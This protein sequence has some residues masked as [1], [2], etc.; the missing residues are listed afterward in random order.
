MKKQVLLL[1]ALFAVI[2]ASALAQVPTT[3]NLQG[4]LTGP[5]DEPFNGTVTMEFQM[6][7]DPDNLGSVVHTESLG[8]VTVTDGYYNLRI[9]VAPN[10]IGNVVNLAK[11]PL[12][13]QLVV[14]GTPQ[15]AKPIPFD[16]TP[17]SFGSKF[18]EV[19][20]N[21]DSA[22]Y[23]KVAGE[24]R[25]IG[26][27][28]G[29]L[30]GEYPDKLELD[31][32]ALKGQLDIMLE[33]ISA[34]PKGPADGD[35]TGTYPDKLRIKERHVTGVQL[36]Y[37]TITA[38]N[39]RNGSVTLDKVATPSNQNTN[40]FLWWNKATGRYEQ[41]TLNK[42]IADG[43]MT[44]GYIPTW[45]ED[46]DY[47]VPS[48]IWINPSNTLVKL[49]D[50]TNFDVTGLTTLNDLTVTGSTNIDGSL[51]VASKAILNGGATIFGIPT[52]GT[53]VVNRNY[54]DAQ[55]GPINTELARIDAQVIANTAAIATKASIAD[56]NN[57]S[58]TVSNLANTVNQKADKTELNA[59]AAIVDTKASQTDLTA[60]T[61]VVATKASQADLL[62][63]DSDLDALTAVVDT[64]A[65]QTALDALTAVVATKAAQTDLD[66]LT[67]VVDGKATQVALIDTAAALR[68]YID[69]K[70]SINVPN[71]TI[72]K[73]DASGNL[74]ASNITDDDYVVTI[75][76]GL[77]VDNIA[78]P[79]N[80]GQTQ[81]TG[82]VY[83][84]GSSNA[85]STNTFTTSIATIGNGTLNLGRYS[86]SQGN[87]TGTATKING[88]NVD[89][90]AASYGLLQGTTGTAVNVAGLNVDI[91]GAT[92]NLNTGQLPAGN[93][94]QRSTNIGND[95]SPAVTINSQAINIG[96]GSGVIIPPPPPNTNAINIGSDNSVTNINGTVSFAKSFLVPTPTLDTTS[97]NL[98]VVN[99]QYVADRIL[100][101]T[102]G[103]TNPDVIWDIETSTGYI[104]LATGRPSPTEPRRFQNSPLLVTTIDD[105]G[106][107][108]SKI[109][110]DGLIYAL[111][112]VANRN[113]EVVN[114]NITVGT[115]NNQIAIGNNTINLATDLIISKSVVGAGLTSI[116]LGNDILNDVDALDNFSVN[117][118]GNLV[119]RGT[120]QL[121]GTTTLRG[122]LNVIGTATADFNNAVTFWG[123][124]TAQ[125]P[126]VASHV[127][128]KGYVDDAISAA[129]S[130]LGG[131]AGLDEVDDNYIP[132]VEGG[133]L[134][135][136]PIYRN[137]FGSLFTSDIMAI[138]TS[139]VI[140]NN[141]WIHGN[142]IICDPDIWYGSTDP[143]TKSLFIGGT[144]LDI[145]GNCYNADGS[146]NDDV[147]ADEYKWWYTGA[148]N[149]IIHK[150]QPAGL[151]IFADDFFD[152]NI[153]YD[154]TGG[155]AELFGVYVDLSNEYGT[156]VAYPRAYAGKFL[157]NSAGTYATVFIKNL[158]SPAYSSAPRD[159]AALFVNGGINL[160]G[161]ISSFVEEHKTS[162]PINPSQSSSWRVSTDVTTIPAGT[163]GQI[164][165]IINTSASQV[166]VNGT[167]IAGKKAQ[168][169]ICYAGEW[170]PFQ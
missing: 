89:I 30:S 32:N 1:I 161:P 11:N 24:A 72:P 91:E 149:A 51:N 95:L 129:V 3:L 165:Y 158:A 98:T 88:L 117:S 9:G 115:G 38:E 47:F 100:E 84:N 35:I 15:F 166:T 151:A 22:E 122:N 7:T 155:P 40:S 65:N 133:V 159:N 56:L 63:L 62:A 10:T 154:Q 94:Y 121:Y 111:D 152:A 61:A 170:Y 137:V 164:M 28:G 31:P 46:A 14:N 57:L 148:I 16:A 90:G 48:P 5:N 76:K 37:N 118:N 126:T 54:V 109:T 146:W 34:T 85:G 103:L 107:D 52:S 4:F 83:I 71:N 139:L 93:S 2:T 101:A 81:I 74:V 160:D 73:A 128:T 36:D 26:P 162:R 19:S 134:V 136:S 92:L 75:T 25:P 39:I 123:T 70:A 138:D 153:Y 49:G 20:A 79:A 80:S 127:A 110:S 163:N 23:A 157:S 13:Y 140:D 77:V 53:D 67:L 29:I 150:D 119:A 168:M 106:T 60:L 124:A 43:W 12:Y 8:S 116:R 17:F 112:F 120:T 78:G 132:I 96:V 156:Q 68:A 143:V 108:R 27:A 99:K 87:N 102:M 113:V 45:N 18:A 59:L 130:G 145:I 142:T 82:P 33:N 144:P 97:S 147:E 21:A 105:N 50:G 6:F 114:G 64:K 66:A 42:V 44:D 69:A 135:N 169:F 167:D 104:P 41:A 131:G 141:A 125:T 55:I 58:A 86:F